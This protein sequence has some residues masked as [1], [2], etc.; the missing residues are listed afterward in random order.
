MDEPLDPRHALGRRRV[1][2]GHIDWILTSN[3]RIRGCDPRKIQ[4]L[5]EF[6]SVV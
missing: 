1:M 5:Y 2:C 3:V 6:R 4:R